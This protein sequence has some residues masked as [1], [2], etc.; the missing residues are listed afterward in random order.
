MKSNK[1]IINDE[2][3]GMAKAE[4]DE[5]RRSTRPLLIP[6]KTS[7][8]GH[9]TMAVYVVV[10]MQ[11]KTDAQSKKGE[12]SVKSS[13]KSE[14]PSIQYPDSRK[15]ETSSIQVKQGSSTKSTVKRTKTHPSQIKQATLQ[16][17]LPDEE[18]YG[19]FSNLNFIF[20]FIYG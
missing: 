12:G 17:Q 16:I 8:K 14:S 1:P 11:P 6:P 7:P 15:K 9:P 2:E 18:K 4:E 13:L 5:L 3:A 19:P 20:Y 10:S